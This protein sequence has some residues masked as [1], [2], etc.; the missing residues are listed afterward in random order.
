[1][2]K[3][4]QDQRTSFPEF[5]YLYDVSQFLTRYAISSDSSYWVYHDQAFNDCNRSIQRYC[6]SRSS[7]RKV[8][9]FGLTTNFVDQRAVYTHQ[10]KERPMLKLALRYARYAL[11]A[12]ATLG[13][14]LSA[15]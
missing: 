14:G 5:M 2:R 9:T 3:L 6:R 7:H 12:L 15:N 4:E 8:Q 10:R 1:M 11:S 13:F